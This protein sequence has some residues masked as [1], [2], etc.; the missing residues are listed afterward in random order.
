[1]RARNAPQFRSAN[2]AAR[3][4][5]P[6]RTASIWFGEPISAACS[7]DSARRIA[8]ESASAAAL[9][10]RLSARTASGLFEAISAAA[11]RAAASGSA[12]TAVAKP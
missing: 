6:A 11:A 8:A 3:F 5:I 12:W 10:R 9:R 7:F 4:S 1:M 2:R